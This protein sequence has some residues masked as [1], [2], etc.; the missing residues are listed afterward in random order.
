MTRV[1]NGEAPT[2]ERQGVE[3]AESAITQ[4]PG[5]ASPFLKELDSITGPNSSAGAATRALDKMDR[6]GF[7]GRAEAL[8]AGKILG[9]KGYWQQYWNGLSRTD[10]EE[11]GKQP[12]V[13]DGERAL[14]QRLLRDFNKISADGQHIF[15]SDIKAFAA[16]EQQHA[17]LRNFYGKD[18][19]TGKSL[20]DSVRDSSGNV[21]GQRLDDRLK[22]PGLS[23]QDRAS[24]EAVSKLRSWG[25]GA[26]VRH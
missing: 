10:I 13:S 16:R 22:E 6:D 3:R 4:S 12:G 5:N 14:T 24:L 18:P 23:A 11:R 20:Y 26:H 1:S 2:Q 21:S 17:D 7:T 15:N 8:E 25:P 9:D 19:A